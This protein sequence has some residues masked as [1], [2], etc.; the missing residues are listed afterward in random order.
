MVSLG[1]QG[2]QWYAEK[3]KLI[4]FPPPNTEEIDSINSL[5]QIITTEYIYIFNIV[6]VYKVNSSENLLRQNTIW[7]GIVLVI[8]SIGKGRFANA[9]ISRLKCSMF[10]LWRKINDIHIFSFSFFYFLLLSS[11]LSP[12]Q[13]LCKCF[14]LLCRQLQFRLKCC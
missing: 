8:F 10:V 13:K 2:I 11:K 4:I 14:S 1:W 7:Q 3:Q 12:Y 9:T 5:Y 6:S